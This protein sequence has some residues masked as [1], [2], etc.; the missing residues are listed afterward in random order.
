MRLERSQLERMQFKELRAI[1]S[2]AYDNVPFYHAKFRSAGVRPDDIMSFEDM[3]KIPITTK[4][5]IQSAQLNQMVAR[6][7]DI[8]KCI[9]NKTSGSTGIPLITLVGKRTQDVEGAVWL[10]AYFENGLGLRDKKIIITDPRTHDFSEERWTQRIGLMKRR[11][12]S[13]FDHVEKTFTFASQEKPDVIEGY[14]SSLA[15]LADFCRKNHYILNPR[16]IFTQAEYLDGQSRELISSTFQTEV[17][18]YYGSSELSLMAWECQAHSGYHLNSDSLVT[19]FL[20]SGGHAASGERGEIVCTTLVNYEMPLIRYNIGDIGIPMEERCGC[21]R[22][23]PIMRIVE[24]RK[25]DFL[26][27]LDGRII[28]PTVFF[29]YPFGEYAQRIKQFRV[30]Q[31]K[32]DMVKIELVIGEDLTDWNQVFKKATNEIKRLFGEG[33]QVKFQML[34]DIGRHKNGKLRKVV[35]HVPVEI[36]SDK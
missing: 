28:P 12:A 14:P 29:P 23:L 15:I 4:D 1:L 27:A 33:M 35:S 30:I 2:H 19:E 31:E 13:I 3:L 9:A 21:G 20:R 11:Y 16:L 5:E 36:G 32:K 10:R 34:G 6:G 8:Q 26:L 22:T 18:D 25:D 24:G 17:F 7:V